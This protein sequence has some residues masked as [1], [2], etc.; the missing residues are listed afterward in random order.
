MIYDQPR[1]GWLVL[2][3]ELVDAIEQP[4]FALVGL[5]NASTEMAHKI[6]HPRPPES[7]ELGRY[8]VGVDR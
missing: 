5:L 2:S 4:L 8:L 3:L 7:L 1:A 6:R